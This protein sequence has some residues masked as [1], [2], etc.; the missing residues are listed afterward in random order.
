MTDKYNKQRRNRVRELRAK[1]DIEE[2]ACIRLR[3]KIEALEEF[4]EKQKILLAEN[5]LIREEIL[6]QKEEFRQY[7]VGLQEKK[8]T[9]INQLDQNFTKLKKMTENAKTLNNRTVYDKNKFEAHKA[10]DGQQF[11]KGQIQKEELENEKK[12]LLLDKAV[13]NDCME[14]FQNLNFRQTKKIKGLTNEL[15]YLKFRMSEELYNFT[16]QLEVFGEEGRD[17]RR[18]YVQKINGKA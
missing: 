16:S 13:T 3:Q 11:L 17:I 18:H 8:Q 12:R 4:E 5:D 7:V 9:S 6:D 2:E 10:E 14:E 1:L 15:Q